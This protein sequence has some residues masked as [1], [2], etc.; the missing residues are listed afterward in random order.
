MSAFISHLAG[1]YAS[2][3]VVSYV[4]AV[5]AWHAAHGL[6]WSI[7]EREA[8]LLYKAARNLAPPSSKRPAR[9]PYT[10]ATI[11]AIR[12]LTIAE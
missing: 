8:E 11:A 6:T 12:V 1:T 9:E 10:L 4:S 5:Q 2:S 3:T 7:N